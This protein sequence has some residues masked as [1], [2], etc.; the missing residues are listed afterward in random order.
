[1]RWY[2]PSVGLCLLGLAACGAPA[3]APAAP[4]PNIVIVVID[5]LR[6][7]HVGA[8]GYGRATTPNLDRLAAEGALFERAITQANW[9][10]PSVASLLSGL[11]VGQHRVPGGS[12]ERD[13]VV[14]DLGNR[15]LH[16]NR[17]SA[18]FTTLAEALQSHGYATGAF[19]NQAQMPPEMQFDQGFDHYDAD[20]K[21]DRQAVRQFAEWLPKQDRFFAYVH[22]LGL[23][24]PYIPRAR[25]DVFR[26][27]YELLPSGESTTAERRALGQRTIEDAD[28]PELVALYDGA[29]LGL[30]AQLGK[31]TKALAR[32]GVANDTLLVVTS[33]HGEAFREHGHMFHGGDNLY[34]EVLRV[35]LVMT[36]ANGI[37]AGTVV[38]E[39]AQLIDVMPTL[40]EFAGIRQLDGPAG[41]SL[42]QDLR[43]ESGAGFALA[44]STIT[45]GR[46][47]VYRGRHKFIFD[48]DRETVQVY[49]LAADPAELED[50]APSIDEQMIEQAR[51]QLDDRLAANARFAA[52]HPVTETDINAQDA[53][54]LRNLGYIQ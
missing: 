31:V 40:M 22:L 21:S 49:D 30:D 20:K 46:K 33:D 34:E 45:P 17:L 7:D 47:A 9:T 1:M 38:T 25:H 12:D 28:L 8:Y 37:E 35:P 10:R 53:R 19:I 3:G 52:A 26:T 50:L 39:P 27:S 4:A 29:L 14:A 36:W 6:A 41:R 44:E 23:H 15:I 51:M 18:D 54:R 13:Q 16:G 5:C 2:R 42:A 24:Y 48:L 43:G 11:Y 32:A